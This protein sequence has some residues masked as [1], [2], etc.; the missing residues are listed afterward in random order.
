MQNNY[1]IRARNEQIRDIV[2]HS[3]SAGEFPFEVS[4][5][6]D[7]FHAALAASN[8]TLTGD[9]LHFMRENVYR[10]WSLEMLR[11]VLFGVDRNNDIVLN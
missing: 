11:G 6:M 3:L 7:W 4:G 9:P 8:A 2:N 1:R 5:V 10:Q